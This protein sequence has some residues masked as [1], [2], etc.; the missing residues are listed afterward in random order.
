[1]LQPR[2]AVGASDKHLDPAIVIPKGAAGGE[3]WGGAVNLS[4]QG[5]ELA[6][7][8]LSLGGAKFHSLKSFSSHRIK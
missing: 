1:V 5:A 4:S 8:F 2:A 7:W 3:R 6:T